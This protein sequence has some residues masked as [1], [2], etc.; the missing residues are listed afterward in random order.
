[1]LFHLA[2]ADEWHPGEAYE[3]SMPGVALADVGF[4]HC[5]YADQIAGTAALHYGGRTDLLLLTIDPDRLTAELRVEDGF[6]HVYGPIDA[7]AVVEFRS[8]A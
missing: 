8:W 4:V 7:D 5:S 1:V 6:P 2:A 3:R